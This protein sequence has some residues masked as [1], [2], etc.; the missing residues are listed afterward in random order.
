MNK[1][2]PINKEVIKISNKRKTRFS[3]IE[4]S[5]RNAPVIRSIKQKK[6]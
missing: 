1:P 3:F 6:K 5:T 4:K 2:K